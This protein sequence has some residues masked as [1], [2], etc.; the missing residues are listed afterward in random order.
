MLWEMGRKG[1]DALT[2]G[3]VDPLTGTSLAA[4]TD[5]RTGGESRLKAGCSQDWPPHKAGGLEIR[6]RLTTCPTMRAPRTLASNP[7]KRLMR[8]LALPPARCRAP[9][10]C[11][12]RTAAPGGRTI[13]R[14]LAS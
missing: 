2:R 8:A 14:Q 1:E 13:S 4:E 5:G 6:R 11:A 7:A 3:G 10:L 12:A 9:A